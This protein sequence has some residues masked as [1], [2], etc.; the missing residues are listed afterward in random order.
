MFWIPWLYGRVLCRA[1]YRI[2]VVGG[3]VPESGPL[4]VVTNHQNG[5]VDG[6][7]LFV[8]TSRQLRIVI[9]STIFR[10]PLVGQLARWGGCVPVYRREDK[11]DTSRNEDSFRAVHE[12]LREGSAISIFPEGTSKDPRPSLRTF[13]T[14]S[15]RMALGAE[16]HDPRPGLRILPV[17]LL[18]EDRDRFRSRVDVWIG[19]PRPVDHHLELY[20]SDPMAAIEALTAE[21]AEQLREVTLELEHFEDRR[22]LDAAERLWPGDEEET[23]RRLQRLARG[24]RWFRERRPNEARALVEALDAISR[25]PG[26]KAG[27]GRIAGLLGATGWALALTVSVLAWLPVLIP[28]QLIAR[29]AR[30]SPDKFVTMVLVFS[31]VLVPLWFLIVSILTFLD[32]GATAMLTAQAVLASTVLAAPAIW[33]RQSQARRAWR[34][35]IAPSSFASL[36]RLENEVKDRLRPLARLADRLERRDPSPSS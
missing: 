25:A 21:L 8:S 11:A 13:K 29:L 1:Y 24:L 36:D 35:A 3:S 15:A 7:M 9:K 31:S 10:M 34:A 23:T 33:D 27:T 12:A 32:G 28:L 30:P 22:A 18:Y 2:E 20:R 5:L 17:G 16:D 14:G 26:T 6:G 4:L 19:E